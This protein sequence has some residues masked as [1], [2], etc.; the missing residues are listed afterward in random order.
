MDWF[1]AIK[2][3]KLKL[4]RLDFPDFSEEEVWHLLLVVTIMLFVSCWN[5]A[6]GLSLKLDIFL[7]CHQHKRFSYIYCTIMTVPSSY[8]EI[9]KKILCT[10]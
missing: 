10:R 5:V 7:K 3:A 9:S 8:V 4:L 1:L 6:L 2:C